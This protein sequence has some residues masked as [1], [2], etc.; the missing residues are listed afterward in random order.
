MPTYISQTL[1]SRWAWGAG[2]MSCRDQS[3]RTADGQ[4]SACNPGFELTEDFRCRPYTCETGPG[5]LCKACRTQRGRTSDEQCL[6]CN[7]GRWGKGS[8]SWRWRCQSLQVG[9]RWSFQDDVWP[10]NLTSIF[11]LV[12]WRVAQCSHVQPMLDTF[13]WPGYTLTDG[14]KCSPFACETGQGSSCNVCRPQGARTSK[15]Q[16]E[17]CNPGFR[18]DLRACDRDGRWIRV[19]TWWRQWGEPSHFLWSCTLRTFSKSISI[20]IYIYIYIYI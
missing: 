10:R 9:P 6:E 19:Y 11:S 8:F 1:G 18:G 17:K 7:P 2:C 20:S 5:D 12:S 14:F 3:A 13:S 16:C 15:D 4:C